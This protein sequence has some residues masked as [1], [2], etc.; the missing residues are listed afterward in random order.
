MRR[1][2]RA[3]GDDE[4]E[5]G[6]VRAAERLL[7]LPEVDD[8]GGVMLCLS[9]GR[10]I[11]TWNLEKRLRDAGKQTYVPRAEIE[12]RTLHV[13]PY[14]TEMETLSMGL[15]QPRRGTPELAHEEIDEQVDVVIV[16]GL[17]FARDGIRLGYGGGF[18]DRFLARH[19]KTAVGLAHEV[20]LVDELPRE[21]HDVPMDVVVT[22]GSVVRT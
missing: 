10:E 11:G 18:F 21:V 3:V 20:Q 14:P 1:R 5:T 15:R 6:A 2:L 4:A 8:A 19:R 7:A 16:L 9:F 12:T 22:P 17:A 13:H